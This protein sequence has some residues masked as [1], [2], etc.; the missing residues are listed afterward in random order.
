MLALVGLAFGVAL[1]SA[2]VPF[3]SI[4]AFVLGL[5]TRWP[6]LP[7]WIVGLVVAVGQVLGKLVYFYAARGD[8]HLP[9]F[10]RRK[11]SD[12]PSRFGRWIGPGTRMHRWGD[13]IHV[14]CR[15]HRHLV[16]ASTGVSGPR[17][18][19]VVGGP[20]RRRVPLPFGHAPCDLGTQRDRRS[21]WSS[22]WWP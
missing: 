14:K 9:K 3:I 8:I 18:P 17:S 10:L 20:R 12:K 4:E 1:G 11:P 16:R 7:F 2:V 21:R 5:C 22:D 19:G 13:W 15:A 6:D